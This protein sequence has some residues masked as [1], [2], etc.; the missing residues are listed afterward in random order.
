MF[1]CLH[2]TGWGRAILRIVWNLIEIQKQLQPPIRVFHPQHIQTKFPTPWNALKWHLGGGGQGFFW[3]MIIPKYRLCDTSFERCPRQVG[4]ESFQLLSPFVQD[5]YKYK[6]TGSLKI[7]CIASILYNGGI[8]ILVE[9]LLTIKYAILQDS[10]GMKG[11]SLP[12]MILR[13][14]LK[15]TQ[16]ATKSLRCIWPTLN[17]NLCQNIFYIYKRLIIF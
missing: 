16:T 13:K 9:R 3:K 4:K 14:S 7:I 12:V 1:T 2:S 5:K 8:S 6:S 10:M 15:K 17:T 11:T